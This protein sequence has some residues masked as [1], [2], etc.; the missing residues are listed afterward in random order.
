MGSF[1]NSVVK[2]G[3]CFGFTGYTMMTVTRWREIIGTLKTCRV[4]RLCVWF[5]FARTRQ[6]LDGGLGPR[7]L[8]DRRRVST[9]LPRRAIE[10]GTWRPRCRLPGSKGNCRV[11]TFLSLLICRC[12]VKNLSFLLSAKVL[13]NVQIVTSCVLWNTYCATLSISHLRQWTL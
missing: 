2:E 12:Y 10:A 5:R 6:E 1:D 13:Q 11:F 9:F 7:C 3:I 4:E 8:Q